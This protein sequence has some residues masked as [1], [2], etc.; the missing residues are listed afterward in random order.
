MDFFLI[1]VARE[2]HT[3]ITRKKNLSKQTSSKST[4]REVLFYR[5]KIVYNLQRVVFFFTVISN[6]FLTE[7]EVKNKK[8]TVRKFER[9]QNIIIVHKLRTIQFHVKKK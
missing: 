4:S 1:C 7:N 3:E 8:N 2:A 5:K 6:R 9:F